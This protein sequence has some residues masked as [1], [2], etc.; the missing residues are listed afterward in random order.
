MPV[1]ARG[2]GLLRAT[3]PRAIVRRPRASDASLAWLRSSFRIFAMD[4]MNR[5]QRATTSR[6]LEQ[7]RQFSDQHA[8]TIHSLFSP[9]DIASPPKNQPDIGVGHHISAQ[10]KDSHRRYRFTN[11]FLKIRLDR[12]SARSL[13]FGVSPCCCASLL[14]QQ[15]PCCCVL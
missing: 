4:T 10:N 14:L 8:L 11:P 12:S 2:E 7:G 15:H 9:L 13:P 1:P 5:N 3:I 6:R